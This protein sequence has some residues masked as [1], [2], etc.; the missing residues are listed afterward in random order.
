MRKLIRKIPK[1]LRFAFAF[2]LTLLLIVG[3][4]LLQGRPCFSATAAYRQGLRNAA[5]SSSISP[6]IPNENWPYLVGTDGETT[7]GLKVSEH[8]SS[9][10]PFLHVWKPQQGI[11]SRPVTDGICYLPVRVNGY[12]LSP[13]R[14]SD[15]SSS[16]VYV[17]Q[18]DAFRVQALREIAYYILIK[19]P[20]DRAELTLVLEDG[21]VEGEES[22]RV[23]GV[24][25][26]E[27][28]ALDS[29]WYQFS[30][31]SCYLPSFADDNELIWNNFQ[32]LR[33]SL[34]EWTPSLEAAWAYYEWIR[35]Y[36]T[37]RMEV[38][39]T[40]PAHFELKLYNEWGIVTKTVIL[41]P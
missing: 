38:E 2:A 24:Y 5:I 40:Q 3:F 1:G 23:G 9:L 33:A 14:H 28:E 4:W 10:L 26:L 25:A 19:A 39:A 6:E 11:V 30:F 15:I 18:F 22:P 21:V 35:V 8:E 32:F 7:I 41:E 17:S 29:G 16:E 27:G 34:P 36:S 12:Y 20:C 37:N 31:R 13:V